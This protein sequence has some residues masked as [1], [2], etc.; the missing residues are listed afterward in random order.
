[1]AKVTAATVN[2]ALKKAGYAERLVQ[3]NGYM[4][5]AEGEAHTWQQTSVMVFRASDLSLEQWLEEFHALR[6]A[7]RF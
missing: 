2:A 5:F 4:Y 7:P 6:S 3:G 1:M